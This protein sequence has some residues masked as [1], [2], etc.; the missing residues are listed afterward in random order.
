MGKRKQ[1][2]A[3][4]ENGRGKNMQVNICSN[5]TKK[6]RANLHALVEDNKIKGDYG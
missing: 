3:V 2:G 5:Y 6:I 1:I 4:L